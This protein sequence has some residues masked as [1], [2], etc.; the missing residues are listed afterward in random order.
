MVLV[1]LAVW[2]AVLLADAAAAPEI[3]I[4]PEDCRRLLATHA[5]G[6][7][8]YVPGVDVTGQAVAPADLAAEGAG[9]PSVIRFEI[10]ALPRAGAGWTSEI[11]LFPLE[12]DLVSGR[13]TTIHGGPVP[14][15]TRGALETHCRARTP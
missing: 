1:P 13:I 15:L 10:R 8:D 11:P 4:A 14:G 9:V 7:A 12:I 3:L 2:A 5:Q 6:A